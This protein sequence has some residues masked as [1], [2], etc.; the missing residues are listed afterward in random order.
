MESRYMNDWVEEWK[1]MSSGQY[2]IEKY[3]LG[4]PPILFRLHTE[5]YD[6]HEGVRGRK[7]PIGDA[8]LRFFFLNLPEYISIWAC[9]FSAEAE[10][11]RIFF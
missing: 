2:S 3:K 6:I 10:L 11:V 5:Y 8:V 4:P 1:K 9:Q 7:R